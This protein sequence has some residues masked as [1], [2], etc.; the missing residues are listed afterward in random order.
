MKRGAIPVPLFIG[1]VTG[2]IGVVASTMATL[3]ISLAPDASEHRFEHMFRWFG[4]SS[5]CTFAEVV[6][7]TIALFAVARRAIGV[8]RMLVTATAWVGV[9]MLGWYVAQHLVTAALGTETGPEINN[10]V[11]RGFAVAAIGSMVALA[12]AGRV[13]A[14]PSGLTAIA[15]F[16]ILASVLSP[17]TPLIGGVLD[18]WLGHGDGARVYWLFRDGVMAVALV[19][20][21]YAILRDT[22]PATPDPHLAGRA[23]RRASLAL[24]LRI[25][26]AIALVMV[27]IGMVRQP[28]MVKWL[29]TLGP[30]AT[31]VT[32]IVFATAMLDVE[33]SALPEMPPVRLVVGAALI[34]WAAGIE[35]RHVWGNLSRIGR[36]TIDEAAEQWTI[37]GPF[38]AVAGALFIASAIYSFARARG[39]KLLQG[40]A[41]SR[42]TLFAILSLVPLGIPFVMKAA[43][44]AGA[45]IGLGLLAIVC[46]I[47]AIVMLAGLMRLASEAFDDAPVLPEARIR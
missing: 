4:F 39:N 45:L 34:A 1:V 8:P 18:E 37:V 24:L 20:M 32:A 10:L 31:V 22:P 7:T 16:G 43:P 2:F 33:R 3:A 6:L 25:F 44:S 26:A 21:S 41:S 5:A 29:L 40:S 12:I 14:Q 30:L 28:S 11:W 36:G 23:F 9:A 47:L 46:S 19:S 15:V 35:L 13:F 38:V 27:G 17:G 42:G